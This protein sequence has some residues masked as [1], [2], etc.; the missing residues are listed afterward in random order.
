MRI[1][2]DS[3]FCCHIQMENGRRAFD[4]SFF[5]GKC[6]AFIEGYRYIPPGEKWTR[7]DGV[8]FAGEMLSPTVDYEVL[9]IKQLET[10]NTDMAEALRILGVE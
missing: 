10:D 6:P 1:Y 8:I 4:V 9:R 5:D 3:N 7:S 2:I